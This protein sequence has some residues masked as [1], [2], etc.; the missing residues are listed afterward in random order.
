VLTD[1]DGQGKDL[2]VVLAAADL[3]ELRETPDCLAGA[4]GSASQQRACWPRGGRDRA[5]QR[6]PGRCPAAGDGDPEGLAVLAPIELFDKGVISREELRHQLALATANA[7]SSP[8][9]DD[10]SA[11]RAGEG[12][13]PAA[14]K[15]ETAQPSMA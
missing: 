12:S 6:P 13:I 15:P 1:V 2:G 14:A 7:I 4:G 9:L 11:T 10:S 5:D 8:T 3:L